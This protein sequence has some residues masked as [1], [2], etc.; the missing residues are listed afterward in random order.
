MDKNTL[1]LIIADIPSIP[2][3]AFWLYNFHLNGIAGEPIKLG[4]LEGIIE[5]LLEKIIFIFFVKDY[6]L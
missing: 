2:F 1:Q 5:I 4:T 6:N 3:Q